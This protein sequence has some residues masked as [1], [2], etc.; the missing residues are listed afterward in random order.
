MK[1]NVSH[2]AR[3]F[4]IIFVLAL[5]AHMGPL[6][7]ATQGDRPVEVPTT[8]VASVSTAP[9]HA[10]QTAIL[11]SEEATLPAPERAKTRRRRGL[12]PYQ[13]STVVRSGYWAFGGCQALDSDAQNRDGTVTVDWIVRPDGTVNEVSVTQSSFGRAQVDDCVADV[14]R[15]LKFP[16][17]DSTTRVAWKVRFQAQG[18]R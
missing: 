2:H 9:T 1:S 13:V 10:T 5:G 8:L 7:C 11:A 16:E 17:A 6:G 18:P 14:A 3:S 4:S 12:D 15:G